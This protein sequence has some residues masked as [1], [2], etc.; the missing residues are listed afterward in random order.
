MKNAYGR[1]TDIT[2]IFK[3]LGFNID[4]HTN[5]KIV[6]FLDVQFRKRNIS[7]VQKAK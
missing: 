5:L 4:I 1:T 3:T 2:S 6:D 7:P